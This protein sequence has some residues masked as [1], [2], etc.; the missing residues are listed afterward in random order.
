[1]PTTLDQLRAL[2]ARL[3]AATGPDRELDAR[4]HHALFQHQVVLM[5][6]GSV[7]YKRPAVYGPISEFP[8][9]NWA[10]WAAV[11][12]LFDA[13]L[14]T[15]SI[16]AAVALCGRLLPGYRWVLWLTRAELWVAEDLVSVSSGKSGTALALCLAIVRALIAQEEAHA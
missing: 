13:G 1:M 4:I 15:S 11:A 9:N 12:D 6:P 10:D 8:M 7:R 14:Y 16:D 5:D 2:E 3:A